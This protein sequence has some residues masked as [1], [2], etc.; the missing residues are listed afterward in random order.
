MQETSP[1]W[2]DDQ[3]ALESL[4]ER[5]Y[6]ARRM[7]L[8]TEADSLHSYFHKTCLVQV[9]VDGHTAVI[10]PLALGREGLIPLFNMLADPGV[11]VLMH[12]SDYDMRVLDRDFGVHVTRLIDTQEMALVLGEP[13]TGLAA[14]LEKEFG[15]LLEKKY[16]RADW[17]RR[18]LSAEM[19]AYAAADT[20]HLAALVERLQKRLEEMGRW[21][22]AQEEFRRLEQ[23]RYCEKEEDPCAFERIKG[24]AHLKGVARDRLF[25]LHGWRE[26]KAR[27]RDVPPFKI[28]GNQAL[29]ALAGL[30]GDPTP[31]LVES[32]PGV[33]PRLYRRF[34]REVL[35]LVREP[36]KAPVCRRRR[37]GRELSA[38]QRSRLKELL[39][40][41]DKVAEELGIQGGLLCSRAQAQLIATLDPIPETIRALQSAGLRGWRLEVL[42]EVFLNGFREGLY[43][44]GKG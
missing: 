4:A 38:T 42:G 41:R 6:E 3:P 9:S 44:G 25:S 10:D 36:S 14:L 17:G 29:V 8:D 11:E 20:M 19:L 43:S 32:L 27:G 28:L 5:C 30:E 26:R 31:A 1:Q 18:P 7:A 12:G 23:V 24:G 2:I 39:V 21:T 37:T 34:G 33:G 22:W 15:I 40:L 16:Q 35:S 13:K